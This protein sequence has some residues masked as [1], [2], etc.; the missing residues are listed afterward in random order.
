MQKLRVSRH[1]LVG[2]LTFIIAFAWTCY[3][4]YDLHRR[5]VEAELQHQNKMRSE[6]AQLDVS[7]L[8]ILNELDEV[9]R[10]E[11]LIPSGEFKAICIASSVEATEDYY[12]DPSPDL[13][14]HLKA[15]TSKI[16]PYSYCR[17]LDLSD[18][19]V[20]LAIRPADWETSQ[21]IVLS[22]ERKHL[23]R[24][25][26]GTSEVYFFSLINDHWLIE[27]HWPGPPQ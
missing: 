19:F 18:P 16:Y 23:T 5:Q 25:E 8:A 9:A 10:D 24:H 17:S 14:L 7:T 13:L 6:K 26:P 3:H 1:A 2:L 11:K 20:T 15:L 21:R 27:K 22:V 12:S 4:F